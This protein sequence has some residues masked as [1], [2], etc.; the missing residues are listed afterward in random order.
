[1]NENIN[2]Y[3]IMCE[4]YKN[5]ISALKSAE[6]SLFNDPDNKELQER[7]EN[8]Y[9]ELDSK[10]DALKVAF[11]NLS[12]D[13]HPDKTINDSPETAQQKEEVFKLMESR[14]DDV[15]T[16][17]SMINTEREDGKDEYIEGT[18]IRKPRDRKHDESEEDYIK[19]LND[20]YTKM[21]KGID[22]NNNINKENIIK[23]E[24][25]T[26]MV[27]TNQVVDVPAVTNTNVP[28]VDVMDNSKDTEIN[29]GLPAVTNTNVPS[30]DVIDT[31]REDTNERE[32]RNSGKYKWLAGAA[33]F[34]LG[35]GVALTAAGGPVV[36]AAF[37]AVATVNLATKV[38][39]GTNWILTK[40]NEKKKNYQTDENGNII[41]G[42]DGK[43]KTV[44]TFI[45]KIKKEIPTW[46]KKSVSVVTGNTKNQTWNWFVNGTALGYAAGNIVKNFIPQNNTA[47]VDSSS[48]KNS[49]SNPTS[50]PQQPTQPAPS[51]TVDPGS[52]WNLDNLDAVY[53]SSDMAS[54]PL[55]PLE[56]HYGDAI[57]RRVLDTPNGRMVDLVN[58]NGEDLAWVAEEAVKAGIK[59]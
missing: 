28:S 11:K 35:A 25:T 3:R 55:K 51:N 12:K 13:I 21:L 53:D 39:N 22:K 34:G 27:S 19:F 59:K 33:G 36:A 41:V 18:T 46:V 6:T 31:S 16:L 2:T 56:G 54:G 23:Q 57:V 1:M 49:N 14:Y 43:P 20:Y 5:T 17:N 50:A 8:L 52:H 9:K 47:S 58:A 48:M 37:T 44:P 42:E 32:Q 40:Y 29:S 10:Y 4:E 24:P 38:V 30:T 15:K 7:I 45:D 26:S